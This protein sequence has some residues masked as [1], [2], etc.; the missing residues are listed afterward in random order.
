[1][2][3]AILKKFIQ[4]L[5]LALAV[6]TIISFVVTSSILL[7]RTRA[8]MMFTLETVDDLMDYS[9]DME[10]QMGRLRAMA[11]ENR[12]RYTLIQ[13]DGR[14]V[15]DT[16]VGDT[17]AM[18]NHMEREEIKAALTGGSGY[19]IRRSE[20]LGIQ[21]IYT[22]LLTHDG[23]YIIRLAA[24]Y[25]AASEYL[26][27][28]V[29]AVLLS[30]A[31]AF[32]SSSMEAERFSQSITRPL[33]EIS[34][35]MIRN[36][37]DYTHFRFEKCPY[38][39]INVI[40]DTTTKMS[41]NVKEYLARLEKEK[42]IRQEFF[43]NASH[44]LK[45]PLTSIRG[46]VELLE[47][48]VALNEEIAGD[49]L[50]R[51]KK[52]AMRMTSLVEDILMISRLESGGG[53][54]ELVTIKVSE[55]LEETIA[56]VAPQ[57]A[58]NGIRI[59]KSCEGFC[60]H[61]DLRQMTEVFTNLLS[62]AVKYNRADGEVW[63]EVKKDGKD[64]IF[65]V[66]D[67]GVGIPKDSLDRI[68]ERFYRVDKGRSRKQGGTGLG[69]SIVKHVVGFYQGTVTVESEMGEGSLFVVRMPVAES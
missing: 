1:M 22:A 55:L 37:D 42:Q 53:R 56:S 63:A 40:A 8:D 33:Q 31:I 11:E 29:P 14:V 44:E 24:P 27:M 43:S 50:A 52:E 23:T 69:L 65:S 62:N 38:E 35:E 39:E 20:T 48:G 45:T 13:K 10:E 68:F 61:A 58:E 3:R 66:R 59:H 16:Q 26:I 4:L 41:R 17:A 54:A 67:T 32:L 51:I 7:K 12:S 19:S 21:M 57:A 30:F 49:F 36:E 15:A 25:S 6:N 2:R 18:E 46:Y 28:V 60:I 34:K 47:S 64:M 9:G 5:F